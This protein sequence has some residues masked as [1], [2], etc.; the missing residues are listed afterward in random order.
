MLQLALRWGKVRED[1]LKI[2]LKPHHLLQG[3]GSMRYASDTKSTYQFIVQ[4][5]IQFQLLSY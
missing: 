5:Q 4:F 1:G 2:V 3:A